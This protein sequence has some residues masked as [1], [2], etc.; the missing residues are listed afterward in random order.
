MKKTLLFITIIFNFLWINNLFCQSI[1]LLNPPSVVTGPA[2][3]VLLE[4][5]L[6]VKN[7]S[8]SAKSIKVTRTVISEVTGSENNVCWGPTCYPPFVNTT[9]TSVNIA[10]DETNT[11]FKGDYKP[12]GL[13][14]SS[15]I[16]YCFFD[17]NNPTDEK[18]TT[19]EYVAYDLFNGA[20]ESWEAVASEEAPDEWFT[21]NHLISIGATTQAS[22]FK[23][24][25]S[26]AGNAAKIK[27]IGLTTNPFPSLVPDTVGFM[28]YGNYDSVT[29]SIAGRPFVG[30]PASLDFF[31]K[32]TP[33]GADT[34]MISVILTRWN[35]SLSE[36]DTI[37]SGVYRSS[38]SENTYSYKALNLVYNSTQLCDSIMIVISSSGKSKPKLNSELFIDEMFLTEPTS[39]GIKKHTLKESAKIYPNPVSNTLFIENIESKEGIKLNIF[40][41]T[42]KN[43]ISRSLSA[44]IYNQI[45][46]V[47]VSDLTPGLYFYTIEGQK[48]YCG[49]FSVAK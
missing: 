12:N 34:F 22:V 15:I 4:A 35:S 17:E 29:G 32:Y 40:D 42:G 31:S 23:T 20:V 46:K 19:I 18:C 36:R 6:G 14:G 39:G 21:S 43:V 26:E 10:S 44:H 33:A 45:S 38:A 30:Q 16:K 1:E 24:T 8:S 7:I 49:K 2:S 5:L 11:T 28:I 47:D 9:A 41:V 37:A 13:T 3:N 25:D 27:S 48:N